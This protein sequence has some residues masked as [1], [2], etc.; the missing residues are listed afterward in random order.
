MPDTPAGCVRGV[1]LPRGVW[2]IDALA[3][4]PLQPRR[5]AATGLF[6]WRCGSVAGNLIQP[7]LLGA[8]CG[9]AA[10][11]PGQ[12]PALG[13]L[14]PLLW[15]MSP[16]RAAAAVLAATYAM[17]T[18]R[19]LPRFAGH[20]FDSPAL[21]ILCWIG[22]GVAS[23][24]LWGLLWPRRGDTL[25]VTSATLA[26]LA[27][28]LLPPMG[29]ILPG[30]P[31]VCWGFLAPGSAWIG[32]AVMTVGMA[33]AASGLRRA[34][35]LKGRRHVAW[36]VL[37]GVCV[38]L[39]TLGQVPNPAGGERSAGV[40]GMRTAWG[41]FP[42]YGSVEVA[43]RLQRIGE[44][45][46]ASAKDA[47]PPRTVVFPEAII[48]LYDASLDDVIELEIMRKIRQTAQTVVLGADVTDAAG[49]FRNI[50]LVLRP[51]GLRSI[52]SARQTTPLAQWRPWSGTMH[53]PANWFGNSAVIVGDKL[54]VRIM[55]CHEEWMP[56]LHLVSE[57]RGENQIIITMANLWAADDRLAS[58]IQAAHTEGMAMLF[59]RPYIRAINSAA[60][61]ALNQSQ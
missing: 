21:G 5:W 58:D 53:F 23:G 2:P 17:A 33:A 40:V 19:F 45:L 57:A 16:S 22:V 9:F 47:G 7:A 27:L 32:L 55:F 44:A 1:Q 49:R 3:P 15:A 42:T 41:Q 8:G 39:S 51:D 31:V 52:V 54:P 25:P 36:I 50:A 34:V 37:A 43:Q 59:A 35:N 10:W 12:T 24:G 14:F 48:G 28:S 46:E 60:G 29:A 13:L 38:S 6:I 56:G 18:V 4:E 11:S 30:H 26:A 20:W 61:S